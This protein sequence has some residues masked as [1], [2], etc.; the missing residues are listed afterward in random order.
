MDIQ[1]FIIFF[2]QILRAV[3]RQMLGT[4]NP[5][6]FPAAANYCGLYVV[7]APTTVVMTTTPLASTRGP[8]TTTTPATAT[9]GTL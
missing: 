7:S 2:V 6:N 8:T 3:P 4:F 9:K 1:T 5:S